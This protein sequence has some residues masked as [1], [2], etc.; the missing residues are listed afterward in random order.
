M[1]ILHHY[2]L[3]Q[4]GSGHIVNE[5]SV[6]EP[7]ELTGGLFVA[8]VLDG[9][10]S[11]GGGAIASSQASRLITDRADEIVRTATN[12]RE[13]LIQL[14]L[15]ANRAILDLQKETDGKMGTTM[16]LCLIDPS[17]DLLH[18]AHIGDSVLYRIR[19]GIVSR[20]TAEDTDSSGRLSK[21]LG[22][23]W[24][25]DK[26]SIYFKCGLENGDQLILGSDGFI[27]NRPIQDYVPEIAETCPEYAVKQ[28]VS[29]AEKSSNDDISIIFM[30]YHKPEGL[31]KETESDISNQKERDSTSE[32]TSPVTP[33]PINNSANW[34]VTALLVLLAFI[35][36]AILSPRKYVDLYVQG[37]QPT[38]DTT[39]TTIF[40]QDSTNA[41]HHEYESQN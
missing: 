19:R 35:A 32:S 1:T 21:W 25:L 30:C 13:A 40:Q 11:K 14:T 9:I 5:D 20:L 22:Q 12:Y 6:I 34:M 39:V 15:L 36:G 38:E 3:S 7:R 17:E 2:S 26:E 37:S 31:R 33:G 27:K 16:T 18:V 28:M 23:P 10:S 8:G 41:I 29:L 4:K 24:P